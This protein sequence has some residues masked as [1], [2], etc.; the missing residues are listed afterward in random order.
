M[1]RAEEA[2]IR[3]ERRIGGGETGVDIA[4]A[5]MALRRALVRIEIRDHV[6]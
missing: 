1:N 3:A 5:E 6:K 4:R 2:R